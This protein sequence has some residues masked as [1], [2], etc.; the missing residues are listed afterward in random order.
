VPQSDR[1][2][3]FTGER[4]RRYARFLVRLPQIDMAHHE[5]ERFFERSKNT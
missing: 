3:A 2:F 1:R 5:A 4:C